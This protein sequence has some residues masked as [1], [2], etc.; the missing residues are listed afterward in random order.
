MYRI[1]VIA[2]DL[3]GAAD[4]GIAFAQA[5]LPSVVLLSAARAAPA[6]IEVLA[7]DADS[8]QLRPGEAAAV[9]RHLAQRHLAPGVLLYKKI[10]STLRGNIAAELAAVIPQA[11]MA[12]VAPAFPATGR[13]TRDG[14]VYVQNVPLE[15]TAIW[16]Q[17]GLTGVADIAAMLEHAGVR[18]AR[19]GLDLV[20][21]GPGALLHALDGAAR[22][23][24]QAIVCDAETGADLAAIV[25]AS[26]RMH[27]PR[28]WVGSGGLAHYLPDAAGIAAPVPTA[29]PIRPSGPVLVVV[30]SLS[31]VSRDQA[32]RLASQ[33]GVAAVT[34]PP[35]ALPQGSTHPGWQHAASALTA[36]LDRGDDVLLTIGAGG[37]Q[38]LRQGWR[39]CESLARLVSPLADRFG[40]LV[41][42]GGETARALLT[43]LGAVGLRLVREI[44]PGVVLSTAEGGGQALPV[45]TKAG[46]FGT[47]DTLVHCRAVLRGTAPETQS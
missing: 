18:T 25:S 38:D 2:D 46:A 24:V 13:T 39:L 40:S 44:E 27:A 45:I 26:A 5:G 31:A 8:R 1:L 9:H 15:Q 43:G 16:Q 20:R 21:S 7:L 33:P 34:A 14:R 23:G 42:T 10:D 17:E 22:V 28:F 19:A 4:C 32:E 35:D 30:G 11:G 6:A 41:A 47:P 36:A 37:S 29:P 3:S 12:I